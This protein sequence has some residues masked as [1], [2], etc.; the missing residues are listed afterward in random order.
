MAAR[1]AEAEVAAR[2]RAQW[3]AAM[4]ETVAAECPVAGQAEQAD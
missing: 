4:A 2:V 1:V 3:G